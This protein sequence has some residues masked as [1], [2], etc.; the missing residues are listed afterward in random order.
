MEPASNLQPT[1]LNWLCAS[2]KKEQGRSEL[3][4]GYELFPSLA[5]WGG[6]G[7]MPSRTRTS[8]RHPGNGYRCF[9]LPPTEDQE[10]SAL[11]GKT[12]QSSC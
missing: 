10:L 5:G 12:L 3:G 8:H 2:I 11:A 6:R 1:A 9:A 7:R 4:D